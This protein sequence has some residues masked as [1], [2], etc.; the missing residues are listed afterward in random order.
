MLENGPSSRY[1]RYFDIDWDPPQRKLTATV[2]MPVLGDH[3]GRVLEAGELSVE[4]RGGSFVVRYHDHEAPVSPR[5][6]DE[7]LGRAAERAGSAELASL[8]GGARRAPARAPDRPRGRGRA[9]PGQ[10]GAA[11]TA[12][13]A[14]R[15]ARG[16]GGRRRRDRGRQRRPR[17]PRRAARPAELPARLL[18]APP[19]RSCPTGGSSTSRR[20]SGCGSR[21]SQVFADTH[22]L[23]LDLVA[24]RDGRR[25]ADR[26]RRRA[27]RPGGLPAHGCADATGGL[28]RGGEDPRGRRGAA[29]VLAGGGHHRLRLP[30]PGQPALRRPGRTRRPCGPATPASPASGPATPRSCTRPSSRS[31]AR[32]WPPRSS[33]SPGCWP[34]ICERHRRHRDYTRRELRDAL[35][36]ADRRRSRSTAPTPAPAARSAPRTGRTWPRPSR[37]AARR[38]PDLDAELL[39][40]IGRLLGARVPGA[41]SRVRGALRAGER[42]GDGQGRGGHGLLPVP[43]AGLAERGRRRPGR[44][45]PA[46]RR[47]PRRHGR[48]RHGRRRML[49]LS[50]HDTKRSEDVRARISL[51]SELPHAW[52]EAVHALGAPQRSR[53]PTRRLAGPQHR[54]PAVPDAGRRLADRRRTGPRRTWR[55]RPGRPRSTPRGSIR[56]PSTTTRSPASSTRCSRDEGFVA[57]LSRFLA[58]IELVQRG[59]VNSLAQSAAA[60]LPGRARPLPGHRAVGPVPGRPRQPPAGRLR[61]P[62]GLLAEPGRRRPEP[63]LRPDGRGRPEALA[64]PPA[65]RA[66]GGSTRLLRA[67]RRATSRCAV[68]APGRPRRRLRASRPATPHRRGAPAGRAA[69]R[70]WAG[71]RR[72]PAGRAAGAT[73]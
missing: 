68:A 9:A 50:T 13:R 38:R 18:G 37:A 33:G 65:A 67:R 41:E 73:C 62:A 20:W 54:V 19:P 30:E 43:P 71:H 10:G 26:P 70:D 4:R 12:G 21:T 58:G 72:R 16:G 69:G 57:D 3:Y 28:R 64:D 34:S 61:C 1:A 25:A 45:R 7:L 32:S 8:A 60:H 5:T 14:V 2:L 51:L 36:G 22:R 29:R 46:G 15:P 48:R 55:R 40:F 6:L 27:R 63:A 39:D 47:L 31:C 35:A 53:P 49:T 52:A 23:I 44:L 56:D 17:R 42:A 24:R 59:R 66:T 11:R